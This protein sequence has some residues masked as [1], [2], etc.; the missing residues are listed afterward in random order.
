MSEKVVIRCPH[1]PNKKFFSVDEES[2]CKNLHFICD[3]CQRIY[4]YSAWYEENQLKTEIL[5]EGR[6]E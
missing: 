2:V 5:D 4:R 1:H 6:V 3:K